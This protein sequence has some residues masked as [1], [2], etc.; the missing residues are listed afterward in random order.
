MTRDRTLSILLI[1][2]SA[3]AIGLFVYGFIGWTA[4]VSLTDWND[5]VAFRGP[6]PV[7]DF[8]GLTQYG[9]LL[10]NQRFLVDLQNT[11]VFTVMFVVACNLIGLLLAVLLDRSMPG[12]TV[13]R[14]LFL[15]P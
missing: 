6:F 8:V 10:Q 14:A 4:Y 12:E 2:P 15:F 1:A 3:L 5:I 9:R 11:L 7:A 13:F